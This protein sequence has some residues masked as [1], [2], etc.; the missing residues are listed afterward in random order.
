[1]LILVCLLWALSKQSRRAQQPTQMSRPGSSNDASMQPN[2]LR[3]KD[4]YLHSPAPIVHGLAIAGPCIASPLCG[5]Q[6]ALNQHQLFMRWPIQNDTL[7]LR[8]A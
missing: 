5:T 3:C 6:A 2:T 1:M 7:P 8:C 4:C